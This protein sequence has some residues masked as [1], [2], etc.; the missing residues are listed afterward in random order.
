MGDIARDGC[1]PGSEVTKPAW[2]C[3]DRF[4]VA[5]VDDGGLRIERGAVVKGPVAGAALDF[6]EL[7]VVDA[8]SVGLPPEVFAPSDRFEGFDFFF[9]FPFDPSVLILTFK[10]RTI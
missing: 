9:P 2:V 10:K 5:V 4:A 6:L 7:V 1:A 3:A 8:K